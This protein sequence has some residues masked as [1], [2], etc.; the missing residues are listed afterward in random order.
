MECIDTFRNKI[1]R[2][3]TT[4]LFIYVSRYF[5]YFSFLQISPYY[6]INIY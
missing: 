3:E 2:Q 4:R 5:Y 1:N 6:I